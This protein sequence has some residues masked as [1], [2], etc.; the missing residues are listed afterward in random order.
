MASISG[1]QAHEDSL[2]SGR[3]SP[4]GL[5]RRL[6]WVWLGLLP[7]IIFV[8]AFQLFPAYRIVSGSFLDTSGNITFQNI[9]D[10][11][12][13]IILQAYW[14]SLRISFFSAITGAVA[15]FSLAWAIS[16]GGLPH[17]IRQLVLSFSGVAA[18]F[19]G[20]PLVFAFIA[21]FGNT[22]VIAGRN[23]SLTQ[24]LKSVGISLYPGFNLYTFWGLVAVYLF[25][26][27][28]LMVLIMVPA[29]DGLKREWREASEN[30]GATRW[31]YWRYV[32]FPILTPAIIGTTA[33]LFANAFG[34]H[35]TAYALMGGG[36]AS[37]MVI[38]V[39]VGSQFSGDA[40]TNPSLGYT[41]ALGM[42]LIMAVTIFIYTYFRRVS[43]RWL[44]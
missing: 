39:L 11:N 12:Q 35:A 9:L 19:A 28:P 3:P 8:V 18:N 4:L 21:A 6:S 24:L 5:F 30:L 43:E 10:L 31:Q 25:F 44:R 27:I 2:S 1:A 41:M 13:P 7:F 36:A 29:L 17:W 32:A 42:I 34:T 22:G 20:V 40:F 38:T 26:Q 14:S 15:G 33:L 16:L 37:N 23:G